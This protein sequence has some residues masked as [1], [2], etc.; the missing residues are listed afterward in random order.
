MRV[1]HAELF[2][3][4]FCKVKSGPTEEWDEGGAACENQWGCSGG[5]VA[6]RSGCQCEGLVVTWILT[7]K[8]VMECS[9][10]E[11]F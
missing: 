5:S 9:V 3:E 7:F 1:R 11:H 10:V 2:G 6:C 8:S 4:A